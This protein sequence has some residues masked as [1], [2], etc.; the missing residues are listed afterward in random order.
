MYNHY[1]STSICLYLRLFKHIY[2]VYVDFIS[3][4][5]MTLEHGFNEQTSQKCFVVISPEVT[6]TCW[7]MGKFR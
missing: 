3:E 1:N 2:F 7:R 5:Q 4:L 6:E